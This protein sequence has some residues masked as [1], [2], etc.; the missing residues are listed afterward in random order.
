ME[1]EQ[2]SLF[3][4]DTLFVDVM[5]SGGLNY[6]RVGAT[7]AVRADLIL[8]SDDLSTGRATVQQ[9]Y[10]MGAKTFVHYYFPRHMAQPTISA[11]HDLIKEKMEAADLC[12]R[13]YAKCSAT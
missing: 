11:R 9:A 3:T 2:T 12:L 8:A 6:A 5:L 7:V 10:N 1:S 13:N 4:G